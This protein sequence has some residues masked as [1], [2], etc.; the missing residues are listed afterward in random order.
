VR[1]YKIRSIVKCSNGTKFGITIPKDILTFYPENTHFKIEL[2][3][4]GSLI[5]VSGMCNNISPA[6]IKSYEFEDLEV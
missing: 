6:E 2:Y 4:P 3:G 1:Q 5:L